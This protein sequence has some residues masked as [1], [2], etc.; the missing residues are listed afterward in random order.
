[1]EESLSSDGKDPTDNIVSLGTQALFAIADE[2]RRMYDADL[3]LKP[4]AK[5][6]ELLA[7]IKRG[8]DLKDG[9]DR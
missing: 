1:V 7:R 8:E 9:R 3:R 5:L 2:L 6:D 4:S